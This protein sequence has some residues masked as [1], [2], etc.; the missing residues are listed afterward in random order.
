MGIALRTH[1]HR[2]APFGRLDAHD[3]Q[4]RIHSLQPAVIDR[5]QD[6][7]LDRRH[8]RRAGDPQARRRV[9]LP[10][11]ERDQPGPRQR[12]GLYR[13]ALQVR[14]LP[15]EPDVAVFQLERVSL[16]RVV[17]NHDADAPAVG[18]PHD[19]AQRRIG[20]AHEIPGR[21]APQI[22]VDDRPP[23]L[24]P[25]V[26]VHPEQAAVA[27]GPV[28]HRVQ[29]VT[30]HQPLA[31]AAVEQ[32]FLDR[33]I[34]RIRIVLADPRV[35]RVLLESVGVVLPG[36]ALPVERRAAHVGQHGL[37]QR[38]PYVPELGDKE[39]VAPVVL[40]RRDAL[41]HVRV[42]HAVVPM[43]A[44]AHLAAV[45][46]VAAVG[47][48][49]PIRDLGRVALRD[50]RQR[51]V[52]GPR[53][54]LRLLVPPVAKAP[55][56]LVAAAPQGHAGVPPQPPRLVLGLALHL[57]PEC[58]QVV[59]IGRT[60]K[61]EIVPDHDPMPV[62]GLVKSL[63]LVA[64]PTPDAQH[65]EIRC[66]R[67]ADQRL[68]ARTVHSRIDRVGRDPVGAFAEGSLAVDH[69]RERLL[70][71]EFE[72]T[73]SPVKGRIGRPLAPDLQLSLDAIEVRLAHAVGPPELRVGQRDLELDKVV[74]RAQ[75]ARPR[76][77]CAAP[78]PVKEGNPHRALARAVIVKA[79]DRHR[80]RDRDL[81]VALH[82]AQRYVADT[83]LV[84]RPDRH[85]PGDRRRRHARAPVPTERIL[86]LAHERAA[87]VAAIG[88]PTLRLC[89]GADPIRGIDL[90]LRNPFDACAQPHQQRIVAI[91]QPALDVH[92]QG[93][94][95]VA[96]RADMRTV[97]QD[98]RVGVEPVHLQ[99]DHLRFQ[100]LSPDRES[101]AVPPRALL[102]PTAGKRVC[103]NQRFLDTPCGDQGLVD[104]A[105]HRR[106][107]PALCLLHER[108][109]I[110][111]WIGQDPVGQFPR[112]IQRAL[113]EQG[114][115]MHPLSS[116][117]VPV[118]ARKTGSRRLAHTA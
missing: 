118:L 30:V 8:P 90:G 75:Q 74:A 114:H 89:P 22:I 13:H 99:L 23:D 95:R 77:L 93:T 104:V 5:P 78:L 83:G 84:H 97:E 39:R 110:R 12:W 29:R 111:R 82:R 28:A 88:P 113:T 11:L 1:A 47:R 116:F 43:V 57:G 91:L 38:G 3:R 101:L 36:R 108:T 16:Q 2:A 15:I 61:H 24:A 64:S 18:R 94:E 42:H 27:V 6:R 63:V 9:V 102:C 86:R 80:D 31:Q 4:P 85:R 107:D 87:R 92:P 81:V 32:V 40:F 37:H 69:D 109:R 51:I 56:V 46:L 71:V 26:L 70:S 14:H 54:A 35:D 19:Q 76:C 72:R 112:A 25:A 33:Q 17:G 105:G 115:I 20:A 96:V 53:A 44:V 68:I 106:R 41:F 34:L 49:V 117:W 10:A 58:L 62:A 66:R 55:V 73:Q 48:T 67:L 60:G 98:L 7:R 103:S 65:V 52:V 100:P 50:P 21:L 45:R 59:G 79:V